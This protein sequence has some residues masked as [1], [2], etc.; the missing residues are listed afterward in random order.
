MTGE[1]L[2][3]SN[4]LLLDTGIII[5]HLRND[6]RAHDLLDYLGDRGDIKVSVITFMEILVGCRSKEEEEQSS[7]FFDRVPPLIVNREVAH[8]A[9]SLIKRY[10]TVF[11]RGVQRGT[12]DA[13]IAATAWQ[14]QRILVTFN[15]RQFAKIPIAEIV[16]QAIDQNAADWVAT[17]TI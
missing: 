13:I 17:L 2:Q 8:K 16:I 4:D 9:S 12:P 15:T 6:K 5:R 11:G 1:A 14:E 7:S 3:S 10:P